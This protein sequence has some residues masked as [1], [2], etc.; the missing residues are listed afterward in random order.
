MA[1]MA[2]I[3]SFHLLRDRSITTAMG[4]LALDRR[5]LDRTPGLAWWRLLGTGAGADPGPGADLRRTAMFAVWEDPAALDAFEAARAGD[6]RTVEQ[7][8]VR[9]VAA[10]GHGRWRG[11]DVVGMLPPIDEAYAGP[12]AVITRAG[13]RA[14]AWRRFGSASRDVAT[15]LRGVDGLLATVA[16][17]EAPVGRL[18]TFS[19]WRDLDA[20][21]AY[22]YRM[23]QHL[24]VVRRTRQEGWYGEELFARFVPG[25]STGAWDGRDPLREERGTTGSSMP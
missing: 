8:T 19:V 10:A 6:D 12:V 14:R 3:A 9:L 4:R 17:G 21:R 15:E 20:V 23:P 13:V 7:W 18:G 16:V 1:A 11:V 22:A 5:R 2:R 25:V 24:D